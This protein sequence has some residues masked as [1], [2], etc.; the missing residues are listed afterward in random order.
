MKKSLLFLFVAAIGFTACDKVGEIENFAVDHK[1][2]ESVVL[3]VKASDPSEY[4]SDIV[5]ETASDPDFQ[6]NLSKIS[7]YSIQSVSYRIAQYTGDPSTTATGVVQ[8]MIDGNNVG[9]PIDLG[10]IKFKSMLDSETSVEIPVSDALKKEMQDGLLDSDAVTLRVAGNVSD[11]PVT[12]EFVVAMDI[13][14]L[15]SVN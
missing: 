3:D 10:T 11:K 13:E 6:K 15:V 14:A 7:R 5:I 1:F 4:Y 12:A 8:F 9:D 2:E